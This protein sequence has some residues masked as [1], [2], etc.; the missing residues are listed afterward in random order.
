MTGGYVLR[1]LSIRSPDS[2]LLYALQTVLILLPPSLY[3]ATIYMIYG[4]IV[5][6]V[7]APDASII[8]PTRITKI[9]VIGDVISFFIQAGGG[10][11]EASA[12]GAK[13]GQKV[14]LVG[15]FAQLIF[16]G[17]FLV[18]AIIFDRRMSKSPLRYTIPTYGKHTW[19]S[20]L[21]LLLG[22]AAFIIARC[23]YRVA[24][25]ATGRDGYI[26]THEWCGYAGDTV[27]MF[28]V[29]IA[30]HFIHAGDVFVRGQVGKGDDESYIN[31]TDR[32]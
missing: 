4:R 24:E 3:A 27:P 6:F 10:A 11:M 21:L 32:A 9:F 25:F 12:S 31:L 5:L 19:R 22:A 17:F 28:L 18:I 29:Q 30:F 8:R 16:F 7:N 1:L 26:M 20:L 2:V 23:V 14:V 13:L 15:L